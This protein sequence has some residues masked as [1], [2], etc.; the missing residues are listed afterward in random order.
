MEK[1]KLGH[2]FNRLGKY[3]TA[4]TYVFQKYYTAKCFSSDFIS[5]TRWYFA[6]FVVVSI[7][8]RKTGT[9]YLSLVLFMRKIRLQL[10]TRHII[11]YLNIDP[12]FVNP[13]SHL[14]FR[15]QTLSVLLRMFYMKEIL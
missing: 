8:P 2:D 6:P 3:N 10:L 12:F 5:G 4:N 13:K 1:V 11:N 14:C 7:P 15:I 9:R